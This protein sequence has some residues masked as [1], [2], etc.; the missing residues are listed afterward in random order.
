MST[1]A[2]TV[3]DRRFLAFFSILAF[4]IVMGYLFMV[5]FVPVSTGGA[6]YADMIVPLLLGTVIGGLFGYFFG[7]SKN[8]NPPDGSNVIPFPSAPSAV[9]V[10][11]TGASG[12]ED[13]TS[14][15]DSASKGSST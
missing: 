7:A 14:K 10:T 2:S 1:N 8:N 6:K 13:G 5:T 9:T 3:F 4:L 15:A 12:G 11:S